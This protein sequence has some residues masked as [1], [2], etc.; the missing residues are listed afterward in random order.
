MVPAGEA[1]AFE[2]VESELSLQV[3]VDTLSRPSL[4]HE[5][6]E[7]QPGDGLVQGGEEVVG[8][9]L[10]AVAPLD[11]EPLGVGFRMDAGRHDSP[12]RKAGGEILPGPLTPGAAAKAA[13]G[14]IRSARS[15]TLT[16]LRGSGPSRR[17]ARRRSWGR[18]RRHSRG[19]SRAAAAGVAR[20]S[21][22]GVRKDDS[23]READR[24]RGEPW[25]SRAAAWSET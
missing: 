14:L 24:E 15:R 20:R 1:S 22:G 25:R 18:R 21:V 11:E 5:P 2:V 6:D 3:L 19:P 16:E 7:L 23:P 12:E 13:V 4:H 10:F 9:F 17:G 8:R